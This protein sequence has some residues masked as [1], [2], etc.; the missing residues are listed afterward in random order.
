MNVL[1]QKLSSRKLWISI[2]GLLTGVILCATGDIQ[3][4]GTLIA[5]SIGCYTIPEAVVDAARLISNQI[6]ITASTNSKEVV[7]SVL[8]TQNE[9]E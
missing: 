5:A 9:G 7:E 1:L 2:L 4:G 8:Q 6:T 3:S